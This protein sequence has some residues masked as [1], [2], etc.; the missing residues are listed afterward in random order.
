ML[1]RSRDTLVFELQQLQPWRRPPPAGHGIA[2]SVLQE[3]ISLVSEP[4][5]RSWQPRSSSSTFLPRFSCLLIETSAEQV[6][7]IWQMSFLQSQGI[8]H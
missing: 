2:G 4:M 5:Q 6:I 8:F 7:L 3:D 1:T